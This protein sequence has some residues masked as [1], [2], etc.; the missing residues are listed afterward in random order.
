MLQPEHKSQRKSKSE[1][2]NKSCE[3]SQIMNNLQMIFDEENK[4]I[5]QRNDQQQ[6]LI[7]T[8]TITMLYQRE[9]YADSRIL[10]RKSKRSVAI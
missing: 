7:S 1:K 9:I 5:I 8:I 10:C 4:A 6:D 3:N 2:E